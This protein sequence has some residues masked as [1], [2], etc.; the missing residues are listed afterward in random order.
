MS[1][2]EP[3]AVLKAKWPSGKKLWDEC[4]KDGDGKFVISFSRGKDS[5]ALSLALM[6]AGYE[7]IPFF[8]DRVPG[9]SFIDESL[10]YY[11]RKLFKRKIIRAI[12]PST[13]RQL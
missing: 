2:T 7:C 6:E 9:I 1:E 12:H 5:I 10:D 8:C 3:L 11:E 4:A 13:A